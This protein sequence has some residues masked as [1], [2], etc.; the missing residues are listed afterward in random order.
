[1]SVW[2]ARSIS[3]NDRFGRGSGVDGGDAFDGPA[4]LVGRGTGVDCSDASDGS[5][6][7]TEVG[8]SGVVGR[9][10][11][12]SGLGRI[13]GSP[14]EGA[15]LEGGVP[16]LDGEGAGPEWGVPRLDGEVS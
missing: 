16:R 10:V 8:C 13:A 7:L 6:A 5:A 9:T 12:G 2:T 15:G 3:S 1:M 14:G 11:G 4:P